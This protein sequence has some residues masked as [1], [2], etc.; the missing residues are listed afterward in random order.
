MPAYRNNVPFFTQKLGVAT[1]E[2][3]AN[4]DYEM[5]LDAD[6]NP[7]VRNVRTGHVYLK[8]WSEIIM[9]AQSC[10]VD[11][12]ILPQQEWERE[13]DGKSD[14]SS[15]GDGSEG[16]GREEDQEEGG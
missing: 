12:Q 16:Q 10:G 6:R 8:P 9:E 7:M 11:L 13:Q 4:D 1:A 14:A 2:S 15:D 3:K 5:H